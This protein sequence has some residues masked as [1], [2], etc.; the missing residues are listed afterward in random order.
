MTN[1]VLRILLGSADPARSFAVL[2][3]RQSDRFPLTGPLAHEVPSDALSNL[4]GLPL[5]HL[6][7]SFTAKSSQ[8]EKDTAGTWSDVWASTTD[9]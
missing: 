2:I 4:F 3:R 6:A 1:S 8:N 9:L 5:R 7:F